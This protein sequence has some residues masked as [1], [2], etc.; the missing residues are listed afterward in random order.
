METNDF[1]D[2]FKQ[3]ADALK[4]KTLHELLQHDMSYQDDKMAEELATK[5]FDSLVLTQEQRQTI[6]NFIECRDKT[7]MDYSLLSY[8]AGFKDCVR[9]L[10]YLNII[11][12]A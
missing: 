10:N 6:L 4:E 11:K 1:I 3:I 7:N 2:S 8:I 9:I 5:S 12:M